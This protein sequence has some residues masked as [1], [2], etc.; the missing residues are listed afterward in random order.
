MIYYDIYIY[1][2]LYTYRWFMHVQIRAMKHVEQC[3]SIYT[4][5]TN[6]M[7]YTHS[8][9]MDM[10]IYIYTYDIPII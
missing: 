9:I 10:Y 4:L 5:N 2:I 3:D 8:H 1:I 7:T 6:D